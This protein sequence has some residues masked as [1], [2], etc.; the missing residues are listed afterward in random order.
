[1]TQD[2]PDEPERETTDD[3]GTRHP[4][5]LRLL[6]HAREQRGSPPLWDA[7]A[8]RLDSEGRQ[9]DALAPMHRLLDQIRERVDDETWGLILDFEWR[10]CREIMAGVEVG[11]D[12]GYSHGRTAALMD[13]EYVPEDAAGVLAGRLAD[14]LGDTEAGPLDVLLTLLSS[15]RA[16][17]LMAREALVGQVPTTT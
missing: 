13:A 14:L 11:L 1:M 2:K 8:A 9:R 12:L 3:G 16:T 15:L 17:V 6:E 7:V 5:L 4:T 10:S